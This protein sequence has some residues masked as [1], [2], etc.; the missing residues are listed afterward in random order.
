M[1]LTDAPPALPDSRT[2]GLL[3]DLSAGLRQ[4]MYFWGRD[5]VHPVG[6]LLVHAGL[7]RSPSPGLQGTSCYTRPWQKGSIQLHGACAGWYGEQGGVVF[8][9]P[10]G[11]CVGW[12]MSTPPTPGE[13]SREHFE[14][15][16]P[17][18]LRHRIQPFLEWWIAYEETLLSLRP[19]HSTHPSSS[20]LGAGYRD[21]CF[22]AFRQLPRSRSWLPPRDA[23]PWLRHFR[24]R[25]PGLPRAKRFSAGIAGSFPRPFA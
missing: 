9:R 2:A 1:P 3:R 20:L 8:I 14:S 13:W 11:H 19:L 17:D 4:Q 12:R 24:D 7:S 6:N 10:L 25:T 18:S 16:S 15:L 5:V 22:R 21:R 23:L